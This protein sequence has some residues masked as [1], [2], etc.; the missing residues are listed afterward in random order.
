[1]VDKSYSSGVR[2]APVVLPSASSGS[3]GVGSAG[4][5]YVGDGA[6]TSHIGDRGVGSVGFKG[7][8]LQKN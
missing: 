2:I 8:D 5:P 6:S 7:G 4:F 3:I 1:V